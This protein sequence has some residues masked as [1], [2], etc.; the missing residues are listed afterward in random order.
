M[1]SLHGAHGHSEGS[2]RHDEYAWKKGFAA[3]GTRKYFLLSAAACAEGGEGTNPS[4]LTSSEPVSTYFS[5]R[6]TM[7]S[8][9]N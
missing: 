8:N 9:G 5:P 6:N 1:L 7:P 4:L 2:I 3:E